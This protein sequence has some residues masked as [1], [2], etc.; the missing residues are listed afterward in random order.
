MS[1]PSV[2]QGDHYFVGTVSCGGLDVPAGAIADSNFSSAAT[3]RLDAAK[4]VHQF[5]IGYDQDDGADV[6]T[7]TR[8]IHLAR[9]A[10]TVLEFAVVV[11]V[12]PAGGNKAIAIDLQ[13]STGGGAFTSLLNAPVAIDSS[14]SALTKYLATLITTP[15]YTANDILEVVVTASGNTGNQAQGMAAV[16]MLA[17]N[18]A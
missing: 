11:A 18:P 16:A 15:T 10:G 3:A 17:E 7:K 12:A 5:P 9:G 13:K 2:H 6:A 1:T 14:K 4:A 8:K